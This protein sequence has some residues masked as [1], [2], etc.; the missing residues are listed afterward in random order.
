MG[1]LETGSMFLLPNMTT[2]HK[3]ELKNTAENEVLMPAGAEIIH[4]GPDHKGALCIW[5]KVDADKP[6]EPRGIFVAGTGLGI[7][8]DGLQHLGSCVCGSFI[9]HVFSMANSVIDE[10]SSD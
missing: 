1:E 9:W 3:Y 6:M 10:P 7:P 5:A 8:D 2:I 4:A